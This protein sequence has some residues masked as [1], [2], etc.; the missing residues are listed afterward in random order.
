[1]RCEILIVVTLKS[2]I[3]CHVVWQKFTG[4]LGRFIPKVYRCFGPIY[5]THLQDQKIS[6]ASKQQ[7][8][9]SKQS[10]APSHTLLAAYILTFMK[11]EYSFKMTVNLY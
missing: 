4:V 10:A 7:A 5:S 1:V 8:A 3:C 11:A 2:W 6:K 9:R